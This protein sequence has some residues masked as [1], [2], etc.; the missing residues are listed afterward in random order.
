MLKRILICLSFLIL[1]GCG[2]PK[3]IVVP[4]DV[5]KWEV[6]LKPALEKLEPKDRELFVAY[7]MRVK[8]GEAF[9]G[10]SMEPGL[11]IGKAV[12]DQAAWQEERR[13]KEAEENVLKEKII[14]EKAA[15]QKRIDDVLTVTLVNLELQKD[16]YQKNQII[17]L[18]FA[19]KSDKDILG[20]KGSIHF[21]NIFD[22]DVGQV[23]FSYDDGIKAGA[24][25]KWVGSRHYNEYIDSHKEIA[26]LEPGK[27]KTQFEPDMIVFADGEKIII[28]R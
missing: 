13:K 27:F 16:G 7:W 2:D 28:Q 25:A 10:K 9:G 6:D 26:N 4:S 15:L 14:A 22:K 24:T 20:V 12:S 19:N 17:E 3:K 21:I 18:G 23:G 5:S 1:V 8:V 11:T